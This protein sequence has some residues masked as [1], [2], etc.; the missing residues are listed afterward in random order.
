MTWPITDAITTNMDAGTDSPSAA[1]A[2]ILQATQNCNSIKNHVTSFMQTVLDDVDAAT[3]R[4]TLVAEGT[5]NKDETGGYAGLTL[6]KINFKNVANTFTSFFT[7]T[8]TLARTYTFQDKDGTI[9][10]IAD[11]ALKQSLSEKDATGGYAGLTLFKINFKNAANTVTN[12]FTNTT[13]TPRTYTFPDKDLTVAG[14]IDI[15][16]GTSTGSFTTLTASGDIAASKTITAGGTTGAQTINKTIGSV[17][18][19]AAATSLVVTNSLAGVNSVILCTVAT[20]D[21]TMKTVS[22]TQA[23][24]SFTITANMAATAETRVNFLVLN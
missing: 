13:T 12:F 21:A 24:G 15:T 2:D 7:N 14:L 5:A 9:A 6:L 18:F 1:R 22:V 23:A 8:N 17:N 20:D 16:G 3:A 4:T 11:V 19:S 10:D